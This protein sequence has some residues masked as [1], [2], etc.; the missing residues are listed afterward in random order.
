MRCEKTKVKLQSLRR[1]VEKTMS[2]CLSG[3]LHCERNAVAGLA[4]ARDQISLGMREYH[5]NSCSSAN[6]ALFDAGRL[7]RAAHRRIAKAKR[8]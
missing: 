1:R 5:S 4:G 7:Y 6:D 2:R 8:R 3:K